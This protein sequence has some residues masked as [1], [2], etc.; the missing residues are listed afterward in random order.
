MRI[1]ILTQN[2]F[3][4][5]SGGSQRVA[6]EQALHL[7]KQGHEVVVCA[8]RMRFRDPRMTRIFGV[9]LYRYGSPVARFFLGS[10]LT[11]LV[12]LPALIRKLAKEKSFD[13]VIAHHAYPGYAFVCSNIVAPLLYVFHASTAREA[14]VEVPIYWKRGV[15]RLFAAFAT[16]I[17][18]RLTTYIERT[19]LSC[20]ERIVV[21]S[22]FSFDLLEETY[23]KQSLKAEIVP[24][25]VDVHAFQPAKNQEVVRKKLG[26][27]PDRFY[28]L[29]VRR[30]TPRMGVDAL[31][32]AM[33]MVVKKFSQAHLLICGSGPLRNEL[34]A[35]V[36]KLGL[37]DAVTLLGFVPERD[38][39]LYYQAADC[40]VLPSNSFEG[41]GMAT[42]EA[43]ASGL[44]VLGTPVGATPE[45]LRPIDPTMVMRGTS[46][47]DI[48]QAMI[49][50]ACRKFGDQEVIRGRSRAFI[51]TN[52]SW[53]RAMKALE[54]VFHKIV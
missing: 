1:L 25:G 41:F 43:M 20:A 50:F 44:P 16:D 31:I 9:Q 45:L 17:F 36:K 4:D 8:G 30:L 19:V 14:A 40:F 33:Q 10:S 32:E 42:A 39:R 47:K 12:F 22:Q 15:R 23:S 51:V 7:K 21:F 38:L 46:A 37:S 26:F 52:Y 49:H 27:A 53:E 29:T 13:C 18:I 11:D 28:F 34:E 6:T 3:G 54:C 24:V 48:A 5:V 2:W 35:K